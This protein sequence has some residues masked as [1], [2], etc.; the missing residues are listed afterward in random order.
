MS[1]TRFISRVKPCIAA[2][3]L[4]AG[5]LLG[6]DP[7]ETFASPSRGHP[8][9][10]IAMAAQLASPTRDPRYWPFARGSVWN[11]PIGSRA[12][13]E[14]RI[15]GKK[16]C[17][18]DISG[19]G[20]K[21][22]RIKINTTSYSQPVAIA[23]SSDPKMGLYKRYVLRRRTNVPA[24]ARPSPGADGAMN[25]IT[26]SG[27]YSNEMF[28]TEA[29][30]D[31]WNAHGMWHYDLYGSG[32]GQGG[33]GAGTSH[34]GGLIREGELQ[35]GIHH[36]LQAALPRALQKSGY[37]WPATQQDN[38]MKTDPPHGHVREGR[39]AA[40]RPRVDVSALR[41]NTRQGLMVARAL[42][43]YGLY[44]VN[45]SGSVAGITLYG[46]PS[47]SNDANMSF[48]SPF[49]HDLKKIHRYLRCVM[50][51]SPTSI[52]GGGEPR[53]ALAPPFIDEYVK[54]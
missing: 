37:V 36:A 48:D 40:I 14:R 44:D 12:K 51:N 47:V 15:A 34:L 26:P 38:W 39:L 20:R 46:E 22:P 19:A 18:Y 35:N 31:G 16:N 29:Y 1:R 33:T 5:V 54:P 21:Y 27:H 25:V 17:S 3:V 24:S 50:N 2:L 11:M 8:L 45:T 28:R 53:V 52:G 43:D 9:R 4:A 6:T 7:P 30:A 42:Q 32:I 13:Y 41:L 10:Q 23:G 49:T